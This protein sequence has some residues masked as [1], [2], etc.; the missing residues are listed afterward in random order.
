MIN[1]VIDLER[2]FSTIWP[3]HQKLMAKFPSLNL[4]FETVFESSRRSGKLYRLLFNAE[5]GQADYERENFRCGI[6]VEDYSIFKRIQKLAHF[7]R[8]M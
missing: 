7:A 1:L 4:G 3:P 6:V 2:P 8:G 5:A